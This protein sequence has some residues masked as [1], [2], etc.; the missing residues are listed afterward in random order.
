MV[1]KMV[2]QILKIAL[3]LTSKCTCPIVQ[4]QM[5]VKALSSIY[6]TCFT[7]DYLRKQQQQQHWSIDF[8]CF[9]IDLVSYRV[10]L[11]LWSPVVP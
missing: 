1:S 6:L 7:E 10:L 3:I 4:E 8:G 11:S 2:V 9:L 5:N